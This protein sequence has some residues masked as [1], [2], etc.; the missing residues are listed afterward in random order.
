MHSFFALFIWQRFHG[1]LRKRNSISAVR[2]SCKFR[3]LFDTQRLTAQSSYLTIRRGRLPTTKDFDM[4]QV[5]YT[6]RDRSLWFKR[7]FQKV[8]SKFSQWCLSRVGVLYHF[9]K[10]VRNM[11]KRINER[12]PH[13]SNQP[14]KLL[15]LSHLLKGTKPRSQGRTFLLNRVNLCY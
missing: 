8:F 2:E 13:A 9:G 3:F 10:S 15:R 12:F 1:K 6:N 5:R 11:R 7:P 4:F 14:N